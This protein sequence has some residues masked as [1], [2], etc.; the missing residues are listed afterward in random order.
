MVASYYWYDK[1]EIV[2]S[3]D[4]RYFHFSKGKPRNFFFPIALLYLRIPISIGNPKGVVDDFEKLGIYEVKCIDL[5]EVKN[6]VLLKI[7]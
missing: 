4:E 2:E 5:G 7:C 3:E 1:R 6:A